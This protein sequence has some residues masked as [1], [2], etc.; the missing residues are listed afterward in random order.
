MVAC[1]LR[2]LEPPEQTWRRP[3]RTLF[4]ITKKG[5]A[6][7][8]HGY[9]TDMPAFGQRLTDDEIAANTSFHQEYM[10]G[11][12]TSSPSEAKSQV[13][14][15][16]ALATSVAMVQSLVGFQDRTVEE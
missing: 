11:R 1:P 3:D 12:Y 6:A 9:Q 2:R 10:A 13:G 8:P 4:A 5:P 14:E 16:T 7:Y 15:P